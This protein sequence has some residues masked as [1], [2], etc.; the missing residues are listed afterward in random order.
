MQEEANAVLLW[1][2]YGFRLCPTRKG[3]DVRRVPMASGL[4]FCCEIICG[5]FEE[6]KANDGDRQVS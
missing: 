1:G 5:I 4:V 6:R 2:G 3:A